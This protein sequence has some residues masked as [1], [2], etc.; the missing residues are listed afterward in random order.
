[1]DSTGPY[2]SFVSVIAY[3]TRQSPYEKVQADFRR[4]TPRIIR[5]IPPK[6]TLKV[7]I[8]A[9]IEKFAFKAVLGWKY[10]A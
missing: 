5:W 9:I 10:G 1:M 8:A 6:I 7:N 3:V 4:T 2:S